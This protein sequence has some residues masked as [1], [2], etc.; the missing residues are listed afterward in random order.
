MER[1]VERNKQTS[2]SNGIGKEDRSQRVNHSPSRQSLPG[3]DA[4]LFN[5]SFHPSI[6]P[7]QTLPAPVTHSDTCRIAAVK[8]TKPPPVSPEDE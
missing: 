6:Q 1:I 5:A 3:G 4:S 8:A 2:S 7:A